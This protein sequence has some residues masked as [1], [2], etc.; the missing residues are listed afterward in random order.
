M[1]LENAGE[2]K[3]IGRLRK[4]DILYAL[5]VKSEPGQWVEVQCLNND[6]CTSELDQ[7]HKGLRDCWGQH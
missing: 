6:L 5:V 2:A 7:T 3:R 4:P 1:K